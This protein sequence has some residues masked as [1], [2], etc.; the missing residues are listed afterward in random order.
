MT[1]DEFMKKVLEVVP[2]AEFGDDNEGQI[3]I[4]TN[5]RYTDGRVTPF[6]A[7]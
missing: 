5:L 3:V 2:D 6:E 4:Y 1:M 7:D